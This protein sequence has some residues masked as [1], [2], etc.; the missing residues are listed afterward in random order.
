MVSTNSFHS[1]NLF[2]CFSHYHVPTNSVAPFFVRNHT[3]PSMQS[4][5]GPTL[6]TSALESLLVAN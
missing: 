5:E 3:Q 4:D 2:L 6:E 1:T